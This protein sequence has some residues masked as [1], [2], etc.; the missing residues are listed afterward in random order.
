[1]HK[2]SQKL[3]RFVLLCVVSGK[4]WQV[5]RYGSTR[6]VFILSSCFSGARK[7]MPKLRGYSQ[8]ICKCIAMRQRLLSNK[9]HSASGSGKVLIGIRGFIMATCANWS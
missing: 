7:R 4:R 3:E 2:R 1:M 9:Q 6:S 5:R 8:Y